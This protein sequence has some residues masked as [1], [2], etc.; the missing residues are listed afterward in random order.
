[1]C[2]LIL[3]LVKSLIHFWIKF[4]NQVLFFFYMWLTKFSAPFINEFSHYLFYF[5]SSFV[6]RLIAHVCGLISGCQ[7]NFSY[8]FLIWV[9]VFFC[10]CWDHIWV[11]SGFTLAFML[12]GLS[13]VGSHAR[14]LIDTFQKKKYNCLTKTCENSEKICILTYYKGNAN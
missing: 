2:F 6:N 1:M 9:F 10:V 4:L 3:I 14:C 5:L 13:L 7:F 12:Q 8:L 11:S